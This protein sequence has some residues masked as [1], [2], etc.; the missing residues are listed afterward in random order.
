MKM[1]CR[2]CNIKYPTTITKPNTHGTQRIGMNY[3][4]VC[5]KSLVGEKEEWEKPQE[6][7]DGYEYDWLGHKRRKTRY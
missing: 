5:G 1:V 3:C 6:L 2:D 4:P 7:P